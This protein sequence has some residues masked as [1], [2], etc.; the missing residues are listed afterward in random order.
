MFSLSTKI[1]CSRNKMCDLKSQR[2]IKVICLKLI[3]KTTEKYFFNKAEKI[4]HVCGLNHFSH[5]CLFVY[6]SSRQEYWSGLLCPPP[7]YLSNPGT[8]PT[9][10]LSPALA[11]RFFTTIAA[12]KAQKIVYCVVFLLC[13]AVLFSHVWLFVTPWTAAHQAP[14]ST[15]FSRQEY[16]TWLPCPPPGNLPDPEIEL[17]SLTSPALAGRFFTKKWLK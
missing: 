9:F 1:E 12:W 11:E 5:V 14:L 16:W 8:E 3:Q 2:E 7:G 13:C 15:G 4:V 6:S 10:L 17:K